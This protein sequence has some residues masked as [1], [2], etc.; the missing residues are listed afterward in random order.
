[1]LTEVMQCVAVDDVNPL[2]LEVGLAQL[3]RAIVIEY[4]GGDS[5]PCHGA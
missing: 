5:S 2:S 3:V 4:Q 1:M